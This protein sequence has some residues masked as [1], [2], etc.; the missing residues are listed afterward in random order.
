YEEAQRRAEQMAALRQMN[1]ALTSTL[2]RDQILEM[3]LDQLKT[4][5]DYDSATIQTLAGPHIV[6]VVAAR[7]PSH[8]EE[9]RKGFDASQNPLFYEMRD[10]KKAVVIDDVHLDDRWAKIGDWEHVRSWVGVPLF[11]KDNFLG[12]LN[13]EKGIPGFYKETEVQL[14]RDFAQGAALAIENARLFEAEA[15]RRQEAET[16]RQAAMALTST[17]DLEEALDRILEQ[18]HRVVAYDSASVQLLRDDHLE[19]VGGRGFADLPSVIGLRFPIPGDNPN[20]G[21]IESGEPVILADA[22]AAHAPFREPPHDHIR[23]WLGVPMRFHEQIMGMIAL[24]STEL[25]HFTAD[26]ARLATAFANQAAVAIE[27]ARLFDEAERRLEEQAFL[28]E[29]SAAAS[30][31]LNV[32]EVLRT[33]AER[34][35]Q[36][37]DATSAYVCDWDEEQGTYTVLVEYF[38]PEASDKERVSDLGVTYSVEN[39]EEE[40]EW[41]LTLRPWVDHLSSPDLSESDRAHMEEFGAKSILYLPLVAKGKAM[42]LIEV[43]ESRRERDFTQEEIDL[44]QAI[45]N[46]A[47]VAVEN[48]RIYEAERQQLGR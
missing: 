19:I 25:D 31:T 32:D 7:P 46:Q 42:G 5:L 43:W 45:A 24:D 27:N 48:A 4:I 16:L 47:A 14:L 18:L 15:Q 20:T 40:S 41:L 10:E 23:S 34:I 26:H 22:Q 30:S 39:R 3:V 8:D 29:A 36:A 1:I 6:R 38:G 9:L 21:V 2:E 44:C 17:L 11:A 33:L 35:A 12:F 28:F 37:V 13:V